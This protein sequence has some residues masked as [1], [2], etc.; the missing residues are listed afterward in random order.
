MA[1]KVNAVMMIEMMGKPAEY[2]KET[3]SKFI[4]RL[5]TEKGLKILEKKI[6]E[7][8]QVENSELFSTFAEIEMEVENMQLMLAIIFTYMPSHVEIISPAETK[9][10][11]FEF[12]TLC[13]ELIRRLHEYDSIAKKMTFERNILENQ[14]RQEGI[15]P[16]T[17]AMVEEPVNKK[18]EKIRLKKKGKTRKS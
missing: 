11:N 3:F 7:P 5:G 9:L 18:K 17:Q 4:D 10:K 1:E 15:K 12:S 16:A 2:L 8:R 14:L 6:S 13:N